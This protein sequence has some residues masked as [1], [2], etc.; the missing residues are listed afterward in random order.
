MIRNHQRVLFW[1]LNAGILVV[2]LFLI[3]GCVDAHN[4]LAA[5]ADETPIAAPTSASEVPVTL[6]LASDS[7]ASITVQTR[8]VP[9][10]EEPTTRARALLTHLLAEYAL[11]G[12]NHP[13][14]SGPSVDDVFLLP[15]PITGANADGTHPDITSL[16]GRTGELAIINLHG[17]FADT[18]PSGIEIEDLTVMSIVGT[19][20]A[21]IPEL[22]EVRFLVDGQPRDTLA[23]HADLS[24]TY[25]AIDTATKALN[26]VVNQP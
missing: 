13:L 23:G 4:R 15:L 26:P 20:H 12:S 7:D 22:T 6:Y 16:S 21:A 10:P 2:S 11:P 18:H 25:P 17:S 19:L 5:P 24:R 1:S 14:P 8:D 3:R 9:L